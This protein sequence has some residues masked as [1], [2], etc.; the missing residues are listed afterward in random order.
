MRHSDGAFDPD[1]TVIARPA[2]P[3]P[4]P[5]VR[6]GLAGS[7]WRAAGDGALDRIVALERWDLA[8]LAWMGTDR[9]TA[10]T[11]EQILGA[12]DRDI[13]ALDRLLSAQADAILHHPRFQ[14]LEASWR[15]LRYLVDSTEGDELVHIRVLDLSW[16]DLCR[17]L[18]RALEFDQ[19]QM[20]QKIYEEEFGTPGGQPFSLL[21]GDYAVQHKLG[22]GHPTDD[23][24]GLMGM[25]GVCAA[26]F[27][28]MVVG[29]TPALLGLDS[30]GELTAPIRLAGLFN[31]PEFDRWRGLRKADDSRFLAIAL[32]TVLIRDRHDDDGSGRQPFRYAEDVSA[33]DASAWL[34]ASS[35]YAFGRVAVRAFIDCRWFANIRGARRD[36]AGG[37][38]V[39]DLPAPDFGTDRPGVATR[40]PVA[41]AMPEVRE[42]EL[43]EVGLMPLAAHQHTPFAVFRSVGSVQAPQ[44]YDRPEATVNA[45]LSA[46]LHYILCISRFAHLIKVMA[47]DK[48]GSFASPGECEHFLH[49]RLMQYVQGRANATYEE[50]ARRPLREASVQVRELP[51][52]P[53]TY[54]CVCH[55]VPHFQI[56]QVFSTLRLE[57]DTTPLR[58]GH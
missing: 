30:F 58:A 31:G 48:T 7:R 27:A 26:A 18:E 15:G 37:G 22:P 12:L 55:V 35:V 43:S 41:V 46:M 10:L 24:A 38:L 28:P 34:W 14:R 4:D 36:E 49:T 42:S 54:S 19:S 20:F 21:L 17:D 52:R 32:P 9:A 53:G 3:R 8:L 25:S 50:K 5:R 51:G 16:S 6:A 2:R 13:A 40:G 23:I 29:C 1:A 39:E 45:R 57:L 56:D 11:R 44:H 47:R 33:P